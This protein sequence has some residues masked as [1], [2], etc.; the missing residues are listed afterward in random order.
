[1]REIDVGLLGLACGVVGLVILA[2]KTDD[3]LWRIAGL[4]IAALQLVLLL[5]RL[6]GRA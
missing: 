2:L 5:L 3:K 4:C 1:M 6:F